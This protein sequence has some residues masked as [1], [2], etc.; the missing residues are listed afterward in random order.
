MGWYVKGLFCIL[1]SLF[2]W[3]WHKSFFNVFPVDDFPDLLHVVGSDVLIINVVGVFPDV[4]GWIRLKKYW[5]KGSNLEGQAFLGLECQWFSRILR[6]CPKQA[7]PNL[8]L[9]W[10]LSFCWVLLANFRRIQIAWRRLESRW[11]LLQG[12]IL[13]LGRW[14]RDFPSKLSGW[15]DLRGWIWWSGWVRTF[16]CSQS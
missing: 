2:V 9:G 4:N 14:E 7:I 8:N 12:I 10:G 5:V 16:C 15:Y 13:L 3:S 1:S 6:C 11:I